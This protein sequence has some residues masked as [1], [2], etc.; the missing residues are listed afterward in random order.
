MQI[1]Q[2]HAKL[3]GSSCK[4]PASQPG[5][6]VPAD[7]DVCALPASQ[8]AGSADRQQALQPQRPAILPPSIA[9][10]Q[11]QHP[12][13]LWMSSSNSMLMSLKSSSDTMNSSSGDSKSSSLNFCALRRLATGLELLGPPAFLPGGR[14]G[15]AQCS[16]LWSG[17][18]SRQVPR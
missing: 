13:L 16:N 14:P 9:A 1:S 5:S 4:V 2:P 6:S 7:A 17:T 8:P 18:L 12:P 15:P 11:A 10:A 3:V